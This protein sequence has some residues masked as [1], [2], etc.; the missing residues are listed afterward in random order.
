[1]SFKDKLMFWKKD[2]HDDFKFDSND[3]PPPADTGLPPLDGQDPFSQQGPSQQQGPS[4]QQQPSS[5]DPFAQQQ[6]SFSQA[7]DPFSQQNNDDAL[8]SRGKQL[9]RQYASTQ[10]QESSPQ[11]QKNDQSLSH[12]LEVIN[13]KLDAIRSEVSSLSHRIEKLEGGKNRRW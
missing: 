12:A 8:V 11:N 13:L 9:A 3:L 7:R 1:M 6:N 2:D 4:W 10:Q 5:Q